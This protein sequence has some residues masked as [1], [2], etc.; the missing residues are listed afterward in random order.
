MG[1]G[2]AEDFCEDSVLGVEF[3]FSG[4]VFVGLVLVADVAL[5][6]GIEFSE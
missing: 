3:Y 6:P 4:E 2:V 1:D 5:T